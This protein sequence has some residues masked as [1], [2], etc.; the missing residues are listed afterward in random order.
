MYTLQK[1][2]AERINACLELAR[3]AIEHFGLPLSTN[4]TWVISESGHRRGI[5][6]RSEPDRRSKAAALQAKLTELYDEARAEYQFVGSFAEFS[7]L[8]NESRYESFLRKRR[9]GL[10]ISQDRLYR[11]FLNRRLD[12]RGRVFRVGTHY[13]RPSH[14]SLGMSA[15]RR[16]QIAQ[17]A[18]WHAH[19]GFDRDGRCRFRRRPGAFCKNKSATENRAFVRASIHRGLK[20][21]VWEHLEVAR[22]SDFCDS[23]DWS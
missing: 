12:R 21:G 10:D 9:A 4:K 20:T 3:R 8:L 5:C 11:Y 6:E 13:R 14:G 17:R 19:R 16:E 22:Y 7:L 1:P 2:P 23:R 15:V 18:A